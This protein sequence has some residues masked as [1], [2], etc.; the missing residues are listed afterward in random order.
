MKPGARSNPGHDDDHHR[1]HRDAHGSVVGAP[2]H[3]GRDSDAGNNSDDLE[4][5]EVPASHGCIDAEAAL[6][7][8]EPGDD[9]V[10][11]GRLHAHEQRHL[12]GLS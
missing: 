4:E 12:P 1:T 7:G 11:H 10:K 8:G 9:D 3:E 5:E 2:A 6:D